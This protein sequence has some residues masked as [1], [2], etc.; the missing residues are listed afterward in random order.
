LLCL[1]VLAA[2]RSRRAAVVIV[3]VG[4]LVAVVVDGAPSLGDDIGGVVTLVPALAVLLAVL[5]GV[6]VTWP[7]VLAVVAGAVVV[8][9]ALGLVDY[10]RPQARQTHA[11]R[12]V[13][14]VLHGRA[15]TTVH[16]KADAVIDSLA[17]P[18]VALLVVGVVVLAVLVW[19][20]R[21]RLPLAAGPELGA[22][23]AAIAVLAVVGSLLNDSGIFVAAAALLA[24]GPA[25]IASTVAPA[26]PGNAAA[27]GDTGRL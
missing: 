4:G 9:A 20:R 7:R 15:W 26:I 2:R 27:R 5:L 23:T 10:A 3:A 16:R 12:F 14:D 25:V 24:F 13:G 19:R 11:G 21:L 22:P 17:T 1:G 8:A 18:A 6:R